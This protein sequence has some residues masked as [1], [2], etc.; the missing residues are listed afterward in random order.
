MVQSLKR[1]KLS[2]EISLLYDKRIDLVIHIED[3]RK[4]ETNIS[5]VCVWTKHAVSN[6]KHIDNKTNVD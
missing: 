3:V 6:T 1:N 2:L 5:R 4:K